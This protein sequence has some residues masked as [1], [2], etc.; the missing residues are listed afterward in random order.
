[1]KVLDVEISRSAE[2]KLDKL[3]ARL[4]K[5]AGRETGPGELM[6]LLVDFAWDSR[7]LYSFMERSY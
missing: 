5:I 1:M 3:K 6:E 4:E 2:E 7:E